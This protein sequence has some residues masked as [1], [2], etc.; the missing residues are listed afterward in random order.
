MLMGLLLLQGCG[1]NAVTGGATTA[2]V[3]EDLVE[4]TGR[5]AMSIMASPAVQQ[6]IARDGSLRVVIQPVENYM[7]GEVLPRGPA[8]AF[9][10]RLRALLAQQAP[11]EFTWIM[12]RDAYYALREEET[13]IDLGPSPDAISPDYALVARFDSLRHED[14]RRR[15]TYYLCVFEMTD[16]RDRTS[17]WTD[18]YEVRKAAVKG[19]L[20]RQ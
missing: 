6:A 20:D 5:M 2:L 8:M 10:A 11:G 3:G 17:L 4:M 9:T 15:A 19:L 1:G 14:A 18:R 13:V 16:L 7:V 12:N